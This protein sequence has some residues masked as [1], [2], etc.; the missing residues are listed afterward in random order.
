MILKLFPGSLTAI[1]LTII[2]LDI[3]MQATQVTNIAIIYSLD[4]TANSRINTVYMTSYFIG[5]AAGAY[6]AILCWNAGGWSWSTSFMALLS[7]LA[8]INV[9]R[10]KHIT[11]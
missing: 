5:G 3:G 11:Q 1:W 10:N 7:V 4:H 2:L 9:A 8:I 6:L